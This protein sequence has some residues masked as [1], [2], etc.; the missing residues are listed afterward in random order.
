MFTFTFT[1][2]L[3]V[4]NFLRLF[5]VWCLRRGYMRVPLAKCLAELHASIPDLS[6]SEVDQLAAE[7]ALLQEAVRASKFE[8]GCAS[9][10][11]LSPD[12]VGRIM[13]HHM[14]LDGWHRLGAAVCKVWA[15]AAARLMAAAHTMHAMRGTTCSFTS[16]ALKP[17]GAAILSTAN[18]LELRPHG[19]DMQEDSRP[20]F[21]T[22]FTIDDADEPYELNLG[23]C[24][25]VCDDRPGQNAIFAHCSADTYIVR[26]ALEEPPHARAISHCLVNEPAGCGEVAMACANGLLY[27]LDR[28]HAVRVFDCDTMELRCQFGTSY[29]LE[30]GEEG[31][32]CSEYLLASFAGRITDAVF[33]NADQGGLAVSSDWLV[34]ADKG[35]HRLQLFALHPTVDSIARH[36]RN[37]TLRGPLRRG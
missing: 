1:P 16:L 10:V 4:A 15:T 31:L 27:V 26:V 17:C 20:F 9:Q 35:A 6:V 8:N 7:L 28:F 29:Y 11:L 18:A 21:S 33:E 2:I 5:V 34:V 32:I 22:V 13:V 19:I 23:S 25:T 14:L 37:L 12:L 3:R 36:R 30:Q 24:T